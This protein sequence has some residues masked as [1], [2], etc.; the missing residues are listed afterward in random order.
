MSVSSSADTCLI[1]RGFG[2]RWYGRTN[3]RSPFGRMPRGA[4]NCPNIPES[5]PVTKTMDGV[6]VGWTGSFISRS[7]QLLDC[8][9]REKARPPD[10][11][12]LIQYP[13][14]RRPG[15]GNASHC[16][17]PQPVAMT[18][19]NGGRLAPLDLVHENMRE[20]DAK[21]AAEQTEAAHSPLPEWHKSLRRAASYAQITW[22]QKYSST[23]R[24][25]SK[26]R[27]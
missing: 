21:R 5:T 14:G 13:G 15:Q 20:P 4:S 27:R 19:P 7:S 2:L 6:A 12:E 11:G 1:T 10:F 16:Y 25:N 18:G 8:Q 24:P 26:L 3:S 22:R 9:G 23:L 17:E